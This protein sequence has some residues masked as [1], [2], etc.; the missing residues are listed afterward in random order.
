MKVIVMLC[1]VR[2]VYGLVFIQ[3]SFFLCIV[4]DKRAVLSFY[5]LTFKHHVLKKLYHHVFLEVFSK[6]N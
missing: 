6:I 1:S 3:F 2:I 5:I 4:G